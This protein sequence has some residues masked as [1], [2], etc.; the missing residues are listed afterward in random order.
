MDHMVAMVLFMA[1]ILIFMGL[2]NETIRTAILYQQHQYLA[3]KCSDLL[4]N[5]LLNPGNPTNSTFYWGTS[6]S[7]P[8]SFGLQDPEF[9]EYRLSPFSLMRLNSANGAPIRYQQTGL[10]YSNLTMG[11]GES[12]FV[13]MSMVVNYST[14]Q[15]LL[16]VNNTYGFQLAVAPS[17]TVSITESRSTP[18]TLALSVLGTGFPLANANVT[19]CFIN[20][21]ASGLYPSYSTSYGTTFTDNNGLASLNLNG[22][23]KSYALVAYGTLFGLVGVGYHVNV[24]DTASYVVPLVSDISQGK[25]ILAHSRDILGNGDSAQIN[26]NATFVTLADDFTFRS[27]ALNNCSGTIVSGTTA[28]G[29]LTIPPANATAGT[30]IITYMKN[31]TQTGVVV[32]P[33]GVSPLA[34]PITFGDNPTGVNGQEWVAS[35]IRQVVID[36]V[37]YQA[38]L[39]LWSL[40]GYQ[41][42]T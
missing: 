17:I 9:T 27:M 39:S 4:D 7:A 33:W 5:I 42:A 29:N 6:N 2:F 35:D 18:L 37:S 30:L 15:T 13:P 40:T 31:T 12:I 20:V 8:T 23:A 34:F 14:T 19:Y 36:R 3:T 32:M 26:Y 21:S 11:F 28:Y 10:Y 38:K 1:A 22:T 25:L 41:A 16:G 24:T